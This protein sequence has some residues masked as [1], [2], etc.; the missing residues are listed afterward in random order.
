MKKV[1]AFVGSPNE[2]GKTST[3]VKEVIRGAEKAGASAKIYHLNNMNIKYCQACMY[4]KKTGDTCCMKDDMQ[5]IY[6]DMKEADAV[7]I[8]SPIYGYQ[9]SA[10]TKTLLDRFYALFDASF[11]RRFKD[12]KTV[13]VYSQGDTDPDAFKSYFDGNHKFFTNFGFDIIDTI[14]YAGYDEFK[15]AEL[16]ARAFEAGEQLAY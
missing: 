3:L 2:N 7:V 1:I 8:G 10:Q 13:I 11:N 4:C 12:K 16:E 5:Q 15:K 9:I 14:L 6:Q